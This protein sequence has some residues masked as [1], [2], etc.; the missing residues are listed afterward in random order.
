MTPPGLD[1]DF[2]EDFAARWWAAWNAHDA[3]ALAALCTDDVAYYDPALGQDVRGPAAMM[4]YVGQVTHAFPDVHFTNP[5]PPY[6]SLTQPKAI[7]PWR[8]AGTHDGEFAPVGLAPTGA[9]V[10]ADGVD[11]WWFRDG[12]ICRHRAIYDFAQVLR[13]VAQSA[14]SP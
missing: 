6:A 13:A 12:R 8:F 3:E 9:H 11:H 4:E 5:E 10:E 7:V 1:Q 14:P 2:V